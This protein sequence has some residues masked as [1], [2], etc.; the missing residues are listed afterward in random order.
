MHKLISAGKQT[1][2]L[3]NLFWMKQVK[4]TWNVFHVTLYDSA[5]FHLRNGYFMVWLVCSH[6]TQ[7]YFSSW[8]IYEHSTHKSTEMR[9]P[10][11][12]Y[13]NYIAP[14]NVLIT[15]RSDWSWRSPGIQAYL[16]IKG[17]SRNLTKH[18][19]VTVPLFHTC[20][21]YKHEYRKLCNIYSKSKTDTDFFF[22]FFFTKTTFACMLCAHHQL[23]SAPK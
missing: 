11:I 6:I 4:V 15:Q 23:C 17:F 10:D 21:T 16:E 12:R 8:N 3:K 13:M 22:Y 18:A 19:H 2:A 7:Q 14:S 20:I 5:P 1:E 9:T